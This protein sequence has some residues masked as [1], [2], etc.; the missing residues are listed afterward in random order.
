MSKAFP[1][2]ES[3]DIMQ[4]PHGEE[5]I[6]ERWQKKDA[7]ISKMAARELA[8]LAILSCGRPKGATPEHEV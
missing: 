3:I 7:R 5:R 6:R 1:W 2:F 4:Q 8:N